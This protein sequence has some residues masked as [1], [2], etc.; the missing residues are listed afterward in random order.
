MNPLVECMGK[1][2]LLLLCT[3]RKK[4][5]LNWKKRLQN[6]GNTLNCDCDIQLGR[7]FDTFDLKAKLYLSLFYISANRNKW[8]NESF[9]VITC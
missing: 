1:Q 7:C 6:V 4:A 3:V 5:H 2:V 9:S 8:T